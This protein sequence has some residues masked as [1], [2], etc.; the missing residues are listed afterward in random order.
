MLTRTALMTALFAAATLSGC[1]QQKSADVTAD[2][3]A[4][5]AASAGPTDDPC[6]LVSDGEMKQ[7]FAGAGPGKRNHSVDQYG[8]ATCSWDSPTNT[9]VVQ[10]FAAKG[11]AADE[12]RSRMDGYVDPIN[13]GARA[14]VQYVTIAG[15]GDEATVSAVKADAAKGILSDG[16]VLGVRHGKR[17][18]ILFAQNLVDGD[19]AVTIKALQQ[20]G[21]NAAARL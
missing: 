7:S 12:V 15:L 20:L 16:A 10:I 2:A 3:P 6:Q 13:P 19:T 4:P 21:E 17:M 5:A 1:S 18:A 8:I 11:S 14:Q 9:I